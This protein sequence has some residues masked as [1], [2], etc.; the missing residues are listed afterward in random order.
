MKIEIVV[1]VPS[2]PNFVK[3]GGIVKDV[4]ELNDEALRELGAEWIEKLLANAKRR[5]GLNL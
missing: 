3:V 5:R 4:S 2:V 1:E